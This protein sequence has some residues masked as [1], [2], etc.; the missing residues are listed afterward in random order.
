[1]GLTVREVLERTQTEII[2]SGGMNIPAWTYMSEV[3]ADTVDKS[4]NTNTRTV[5]PDDSIIEWDDDSME[6]ADVQSVTDAGA[7]TLYSR[8]YLE[9]T[10][11]THANGVK[12]IIDPPFPKIARFNALVSV[13]RMLPTL[14]LHATTTDTATTFIS[15]AP[16]TLPVAVTDVLPFIYALD[17]STY[18]T[19]R[20]GINYE[21]LH[22]FTPKKIQFYSGALEGAALV[23]PYTK[24]FTDPETIYDADTAS[25]PTYGSVLD[26]DLDD[27]GVPSSLQAFMPMA[28]A[29]FLLEGKEVPTVQA[30]YVRRQYE[31]QNTPVG[32]RTSVAKS[33]WRRFIEQVH[34]EKM[35][36]LA[37][38]PP[39]IQVR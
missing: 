13:I 37:S 27:C 1:M 34:L 8:G 11:A 12:V 39:T 35:R 26:V 21:V 7:V 25:P 4:F 19:L 10:A 6:L 15:S 22:W 33:L 17:G 5:I 24:D 38:N 16:Q 36:Q 32:S 31:T 14:Q 9:T 20:E 23:I 18:V 28:V 2:N 29:S 3:I 30:E